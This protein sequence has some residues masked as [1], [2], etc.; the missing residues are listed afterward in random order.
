[1]K[2]TKLL[3]VFPGAFA[4]L[5]LSLAC[6]K[7]FLNRPPLGTT[8]QLILANKAG[9]EA[10]LIGA[11]SLLDGN[12]SNNS[13]GWYSAASNWVYGSMCADDAYRGS[14]TSDESDLYSLALWETI[15]KNSIAPNKWDLAFD[16]V[17]RSNEVL[18]EMRIATD[19]TPSDTTV[20][21][22][23][24]R[25]LRGFYNFELKKV[26][27]NPPYADESATFSSGKYLIANED[28]AGN[29]LDIWPRIE[30]DF[31]YAANSL[32]DQQS[33]KGRANKSAANAFL[34]KAYMFE[35]KYAAAKPILDAL[36]SGGITAGGLPYALQGNYQN[37]FNPD[38][39]A[40]NSAESVFAAQMSV[41]DGGDL[42]T[43]NGGNGNYG[44]LLNFP[45][46]GGP[47]WCCGFDNP[48]QDLANAFKTDANGLPLLD[49]DWAGNNV[50]DP[51]TPYV[52]T[53]DPRIDWVM[54]RKG[55]PYLDWGLHPGDAWIREPS[56]DGHFSPKKNLYAKTQEGLLSSAGDYWASAELTANNVNLI[57]FAD[58]LLWDAECE[59]EIGSLDKAENYV[60]QVRQRAANK[61]SWV[62]VNVSDGSP[63]DFNAQ[64]YTYN[65]G[66]GTKPA[67][68][69][70]IGLYPAG[71]FTSG[72]QDYA[73]KAIRFERRLELAEE[74][75]RFFDLQRWD[76]GTGYMAN[77][78]N[79]YAIHSATVVFSAG[80]QDAFFTQ[81]KN[82][83]FPI[84]QSEIDLENAGNKKILKQNP[85]Y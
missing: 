40:K 8:D 14:A 44:D 48:S 22:G 29:F 74:G 36:V 23:E 59:A 63:A 65:S 51:T 81:G 61:S 71:A 45:Y 75:H 77:V 58:I 37:N 57:R 76:N 79:A 35:H 19:L 3:P 73:H 33:S 12:G 41:N 17:S 6:N 55:I 67:D 27:G 13:N 52:G 50:S 31:Q 84:P 60:N 82:E 1:M 47:G 83:Y 62:Y 28:T 70:F 38:P 64:N 32:P 26:F 5:V 16:G 56:S 25:F 69:Y 24:A 66:P 7:T 42:S 72:G 46:G 49:D 68:N 39:T 53:L 21:S 78:L 11:Y 18:R 54:G 2:K 34:A 10:L 20:I 4:L 80:Y 9:V 15:A 30:A 85:G 43:G